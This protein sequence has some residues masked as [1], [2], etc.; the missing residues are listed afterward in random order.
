MAELSLVML[1]GTLREGRESEKVAKHVR[2]KIAADYPEIEL[3]FIDVR[4]LNMPNTDDGP[5]LAEFNPGFRDAMQVA[6]GI[7]MVVPEYNRSMP[8]SFKRA[9]DM[10]TTPYV[11]KSVGMVTVSAGIYGGVRLAES[12]L[13]SLRNVGLVSNRIDLSIGTVEQSVSEQGF[14][15]PKI[16]KAYQR[17]MEELI[18]LTKA[19]KAARNQ[20]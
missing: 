9:F 15:D 4:D 5:R 8:G 7:I 19:L 10:L 1:L 17:F 12:I 14:E 3:T 16:E 2:A 20:G 6:D 18:W 13:P 11:R